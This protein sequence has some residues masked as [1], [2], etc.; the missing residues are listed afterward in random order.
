MDAAE[1]DLLDRDLVE[2]AQ[3]GDREAF[4]I[5]ARSHGDRLMSI[6]QRILRDV[7]RAEDAV[8]QTLVI[9]WRELPSLRD[10]DRFDAWLQRLL[11]NASYAEARR[12]R[13][14]NANVRILPVDGPAGP[15]ETISVDDRDRLDRGFRRLPPE[16]RAILVFTHYLGLTPDRDRRSARHSGGDGPFPTSLRPSGDARGHRGRRAC[17]RGG[18]RATAM[19]D[20]REL[21]RLLGAYF[22]DGADE[23]AD[24]VIDAALDQIDHTDQ[25]RPWRLPR[26]FPTM[27]MPIRIAAAAVIGVLAVGGA[28]YLSRPAQPSVGPPG[29][30]PSASASAALPWSRTG[31]P[32]VDRDVAGITIALADGRVLVAGGGRTALSSAEIYDPATAAWVATG[33]LHDARSYPVAVRLSDGR[34]LVAGGDNG[35]ANLA[36][37]ELF[38][39][40]TGVW[41]R[42]GQ[43]KEARNQAF[44]V[45]LSDGKVLVGGKGTDAGVL[46]SAELFD[47]ATGVWTRTG[48]LT[49]GRAGPLSATLLSDGRALVTGG[50]TADQRSAELFQPTTGT[51]AATG[52]T[53]LRRVDEQTAVLLKDGRVLS[54]GGRPTASELFDPTTGTWTTTGPLGASYVD[55]LVSVALPDG[56]VFMAGGGPTAAAHMFDPTTNQ[57]SPIGAIDGARFVR[58]ASLL[59]DGRVLVV[60]HDTAGRPGAVVYDPSAG[61]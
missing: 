42:T 43:M 61:N 31:S 7:G 52:Q 29:L 12:S 59:Q 39:P 17:R 56:R 2:S 49:T 30:T 3:H 18:R 1:D 27:T 40:T 32:A 21:D 5:L 57:W 14:W 8:Q 10:P 28:F 48:D 33:S 46:P 36:S 41:T 20:Q 6:A 26:R 45:L 11:V 60:T 54:I 25:R 23:L 53:G 38:D 51:W 35:D 50:F 9:A 55:L 44:A 58:S 16:Q 4:A 34:V 13:A 22:V 47:P 19:T 15:D 37:A 24:R